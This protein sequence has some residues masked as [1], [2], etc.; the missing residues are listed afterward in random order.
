[1]LCW[2]VDEA[3]TNICFGAVG[4]ITEFLVSGFGALMDWKFP[5]VPTGTARFQEIP[6]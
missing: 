3:S 4:A 6:I 5:G 2:S 1:M